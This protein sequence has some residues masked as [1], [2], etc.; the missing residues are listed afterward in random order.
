MSTSLRAKAL[1][2]G[3]VLLL[4]ASTP[5]EAACHRFATWR[6]PTPQRCPV[7]LRPTGH[8]E[9]KPTL[10]VKFVPLPPM[11]DQLELAKRTSPQAHDA[12]L[13]NIDEVN[14]SIA[15]NLAVERHRDELNNIITTLE[16]NK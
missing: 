10:E 12:D 1:R 14:D 8:L 2:L 11:L 6:Y 13:R 5:S 9:A 4:L 16:N 3:G 15:H 7:G